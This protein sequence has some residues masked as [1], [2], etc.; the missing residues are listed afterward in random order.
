[1]DK[2]LQ[3]KINQIREMLKM[4]GGDLEVVEYDGKKNILSVRLKGMCTH[5]PMAEMTVKQG[6][7]GVL[8]KDFP[9][10]KVK[11]VN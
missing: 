2:K 7:E 4:D 3:D 6:I 10:I 8:K 11:R 9:K 1:M 5:C